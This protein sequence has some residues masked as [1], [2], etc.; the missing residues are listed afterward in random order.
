MNRVMSFDMPDPYA[1]EVRLC[2]FPTG[3]SAPLPEH[4]AWIRETLVSQSKNPN[5]FIRLWG[6]ASHLGGETKNMALSLARAK[7]VKAALELAAGQSLVNIEVGGYGET[8]SS[9]GAKDD[10]ALFRA[11]DVYVY[12]G[13]VPPAPKI[14]P[15]PPNPTTPEEPVEKM[16]VGYFTG[17][18]AELLGGVSY[19]TGMLWSSANEDV[20]SA[21]LRTLSA[22]V[23]LGVHVNVFLVVAYGVTDKSQLL[24]LSTSGFDWSLSLGAHI[25][26]ILK[27]AKYLV[28][29]LN[30]LHKIGGARTVKTVKL[31]YEHSFMSNLRKMINELGLKK[32]VSQPTLLLIDLGGGLEAGIYYGSSK[33]THL[34]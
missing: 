9:G 14:P 22:G 8:R 2:G 23:Q 27:D 1:P 31:L 4:L 21:R 5:V 30:T 20:F 34:D 25:S 15:P 19:A 32:G 33:I 11:V 7:A 18:G 17:F 28:K 13:H 26:E 3:Q 6:Y 29:F 16:Y 12:I 10:S 24:G